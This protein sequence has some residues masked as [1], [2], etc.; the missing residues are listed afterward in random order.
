VE[1]LVFDQASLADASAACPATGFQWLDFSHEEV[2]ADPQAFASR[3][4]EFTGVHLFEEHLVDCV[5]LAHP[6]FFDTTR[7]YDMIVFRKLVTADSGEALVTA[8]PAAE[9]GVRRKPMPRAL[10]QIQ[11][12]P[13]TF[14]CS[15]HA[16]VTVR[17]G[18]SKTFATFRAR[19]R[20]HGERS[21]NGAATRLPMR[22]DELMLRLLNVMVDRYLELRAPLAT[23]LDRW[24]RELL[25]PY[26]AFSDWAA[27]L[28]AR[29]EI[30]R[31]ESLSEEQVD[32]LQ[33][34][35]DSVLDGP[36]SPVRESVLV[37]INDVIEHTHRVLNHARR[38]EA[39]IES[40]VQLNFSAQAHRTNRIVQILT[41]VTVIFAP[42]NLLAG[43]YGMNFEKIPGAHEPW[44][45]WFMIGTMGLI[46]L[47]LM[48]VFSA[49]R[50]IDR[51]R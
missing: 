33:E 47:L 51:S 26:R 28:G 6:S 31:L 34:Y 48:L 42:L 12:R 50:Y 1:R 2:A 45:F 11:T 14:F 10:A 21:S 22:A 16:L 44:G 37:R 3:V 49:K 36:E 29:I 4:F 38:L 46:A 15:D 43:I 20:Q 7:D 39:T 23:Q 25:D 24:Q 41:V 9:V 19:V 8:P 27:L 13:V 35:R 18:N 5:N 40:A 30:R 17:N 32:A